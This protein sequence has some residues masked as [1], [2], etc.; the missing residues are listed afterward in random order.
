MEEIFEE[1]IEE[2]FEGVFEEVFRGGIWRK[3]EIRR[4]I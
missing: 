1:V 4:E 2:V 3:I